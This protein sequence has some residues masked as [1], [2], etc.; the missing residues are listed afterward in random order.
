[1]EHEQT[2]I[3]YNIFYSHSSNLT[4]SYLSASAPQNSTILSVTQLHKHDSNTM[5]DEFQIPVIISSFVNKLY[6]FGSRL[7]AS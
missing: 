1:M 4:K 2:T 7:A 3:T 5:A 6:T